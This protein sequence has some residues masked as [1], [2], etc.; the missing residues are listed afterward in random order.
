MKIKKKQKLREV[1]LKPK[2][3]IKFNYQFPIRK[4]KIFKL[5][6]TQGSPTVITR[7]KY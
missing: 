3:E 6:C 7:I 1:K 4:E 2:G 5:N